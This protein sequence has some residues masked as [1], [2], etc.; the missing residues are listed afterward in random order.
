[1]IKLAYAGVLPDPGAP[2]I[3]KY[4]FVALAY[5]FMADTFVVGPHTL[6]TDK[7]LC[8]SKQYYPCAIIINKKDVSLGRTIIF[9]L[10]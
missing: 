8:Y 6:N 9:T 10:R 4:K 5:P 3:K 2:T 7:M 1:M